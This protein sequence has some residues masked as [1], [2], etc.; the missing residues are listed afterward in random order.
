MSKFAGF[1]A[2]IG[3]VAVLVGNFMPELNGQ[4]YLILAGGVLAI[5]SAI[6]SF[7]SNQFGY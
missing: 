1:L 6:I 3:G 7:R 2:G 4:Y 5:L